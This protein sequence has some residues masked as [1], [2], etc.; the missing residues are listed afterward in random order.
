MS[1]K[2]QQILAYVRQ[3]GSITTQAATE[4]VGGNL[5][6]NAAFHVGQTLSRMVFHGMIRRVKPG[7]FVEATGAP[8][9]L[10]SLFLLDSKKAASGE[11]ANLELR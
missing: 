4:L 5:Y 1:P 2:Q 3:H 6:A 11:P 10:D 7:H 9:S 8:V